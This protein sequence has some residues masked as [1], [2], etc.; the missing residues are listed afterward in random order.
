MRSALGKGLDALISEDTVASVAAAAK[1]QAP[2][3]I[4]LTKI[5]ANP[6]QPRRRFSEESLRELT[7][8][9]KARGVLQP[10]LVTLL[11]D[12]NYEIIAGERRWRAA[13]K[14]GL[15]EIPALI[16]EGTEIERFEM[17]LIENIQREDLN[18][19]EQAEGFRRLQEEFGMT[20]EKIAQ[21]IG[22]DR[23]VIAN[24]LRLLG[25][26]EEIRQA[27]IDEK[28][29]AGHARAL[30]G[31]EDPAA[32]AALF[33]RIL[34]E[35]LPVRT[36]EQAV[37]DH[38]QVAVKGHVRGA[39]EDKKPAEVRAIEEDLQRVLARKV[40]LHSNASHK[41]WIKLEFYSLDDLD[42]LLARLK[43]AG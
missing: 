34:T 6:K 11:P 41:G 31:L 36:V 1:P 8:S 13:Q 42:A 28:I 37:R 32:R 12:G 22:K 16:K 25:L 39:S 10:I 7:A 43:K 3:A 38:K 14:A 19:I 40:E 30:A 23:A 21:I 26:S 17:A 5:K 27:I 33:Q 29:S 15:A 18:A 20:Q 9:V 24:T 4:P 2:A 35:Q